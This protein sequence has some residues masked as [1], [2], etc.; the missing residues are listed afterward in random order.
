MG[1]LSGAT[2]A[3]ATDAIME[4]MEVV[5]T[6]PETPPANVVMDPGIAVVVVVDD[7]A[8]P[9]ETFPKVETKTLINVIRKTPKTDKL[10][11]R[12]ADAKLLLLCTLY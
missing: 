10:L 9:E 8:P 2:S 7:D 12:S 1:T 4:A 6:I 5:S 3:G 11:I